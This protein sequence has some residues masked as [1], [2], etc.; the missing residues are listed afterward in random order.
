VVAMIGSS[1]GCT[2][3]SVLKGKRSE[4]MGMKY[5]LC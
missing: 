2:G 3:T 5:T 4:C 1:V